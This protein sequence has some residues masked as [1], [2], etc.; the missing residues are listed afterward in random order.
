MI[1]FACE[2]LRWANERAVMDKFGQR[3]LTEEEFLQY[4]KHLQL[5]ETPFEKDLLE[6]LE[7]E[8]LLRPAA[9]VVFPEGIVR[10]FWNTA[11]PDQMDPVL[12]VETD[13]ERLKAADE[14]NRRI[15]YWGDPHFNLPLAHPLD[16]LEPPYASFVTN[17]FSPRTFKPWHTFVVPVGK[18][19]DHVRS[20][21]TMDTYYH[22]WHAFRFAEILRTGFHIPVNLQDPEIWAKASVWKLDEIPVDRKKQYL[23]LAG[24]Y[25][26]A[27]CDRYVIEFEAIA[28]FAA[29]ERRSLTETIKHQSGSRWTLDGQQA[30]TFQETRRQLA[31]STAEQYAL[32]ADTLFIFVCWQC[33]QWAEWRRI[34]RHNMAEAYQ[35]NIYKS[36]ELYLLLTKG[37]FSDIEDKLRHKIGF[38][39]AFDILFPDWLRESRDRASHYIKTVAKSTRTGPWPA[40][41]ILTD[42]DVDEFLDWIEAKGLY[43]LFWNLSHV[44][45]VGFEEDDITKTGITIEVL[46]VA[47][48]SE[49]AANILLAQ[50]GIELSGKTLF[51]KIKAI[52][53]SVKDVLH[54]L[55]MHSSLTRPVKVSYEVLEGQ[56][57]ALPHQNAHMP[58]SKDM[59]KMVLVRNQ[60][61]HLSLQSLKR[62][63]LYDILFLLVRGMMTM[64]KHSGSTMQTKTASP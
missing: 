57:T 20:A 12:P 2:F 52:W 42:D 36:L 45:K 63:A 43:Q 8:Q 49:H 35:K 34:E 46:G 33:G 14:L 59:L 40:D 24:T 50:R 55:G 58:I 3:F 18:V 23:K 9:R 44:E 11:Y 61:S 38:R 31:R 56:I 7:K 41:Y 62:E 51:S 25:G 15:Q 6:F 32:N 37:E 5:I 1:G 47:Q 30:L 29:S 53:K 4:A 39:A 13:V 10:H 16:S 54:V 26:A 22:Y 64:L 27:D 21:S 28:Y 17:V 48:L 19:G 60:G